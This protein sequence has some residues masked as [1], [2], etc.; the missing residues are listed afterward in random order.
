MNLNFLRDQGDIGQYWNNEVVLFQNNYSDISSLPKATDLINLF[1]GKFE[2]GEWI[3]PIDV[4]INSSYIDQYGDHQQDLSID[5]NAAMTYYQNGFSLC[6][7]DMSE[8]I[9][10]ISALKSK[11]IEIFGYSEL[12]AVSP[13][14][15]NR[16][17]TL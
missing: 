3:K 15:F 10:D 12:I 1:T 11:A 2:A 14:Q 9:D 16:R 13:P 8:H 4:K 17:I 6:L 5:I 7:G